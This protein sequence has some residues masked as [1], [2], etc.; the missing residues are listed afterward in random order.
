M[1]VIPKSEISKK[2]YV[3]EYGEIPKP[4]PIIVKGPPGPP[5]PSGPPGTPGPQGKGLGQG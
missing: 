1:K 5:G 4:E 3:Q 2:Y